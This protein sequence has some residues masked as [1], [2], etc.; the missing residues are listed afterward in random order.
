MNYLRCSTTNLLFVFILFY[1]MPSLVFAA[2]VELLQPFDM[3]QVSITDSYHVN[4][5][6]EEIS[7][8]QSIEPGRLLVGFKETAGL[9]TS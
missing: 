2:D 3:E 8:L 5:F 7:Y 1:A 4:A 6:N 9:S